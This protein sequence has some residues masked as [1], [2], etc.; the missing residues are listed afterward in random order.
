MKIVAEGLRRVVY[1]HVFIDEDISART[2]KDA[3]GDGVHFSFSIYDQKLTGDFH[4]QI[5]ISQAE[6]T[7]MFMQ[8][9]SEQPLEAVV[10]AM[11]KARSKAR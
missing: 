10:A 4:L 9:W 7:R 5:Q 2:S 8:A 3:S 1:R 6:I 11:Q